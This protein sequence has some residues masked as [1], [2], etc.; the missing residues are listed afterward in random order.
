MTGSDFQCDYRSVGG[1]SG[2]DV[3]IS[4]RQEGDSQPILDYSVIEW[5]DSPKKAG[6]IT[7]PVDVVERL[8]SLFRDHN[9]GSWP[10]LSKIE[11]RILDAP[12]ESV[13]ITV[14]GEHCYFEYD[15]SMPDGCWGLHHKIREILKEY[16]PE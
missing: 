6:K 8:K 14:D 11:E 10:K 9:M 7:G 16:I 1:M 13:S 4:L 12:T 15:D 3:T 5:Y 2:E